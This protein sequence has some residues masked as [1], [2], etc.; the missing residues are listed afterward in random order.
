MKRSIGAIVA[1]LALCL[2]AVSVANAA[3]L[4]LT[5][6]SVS[7]ITAAD[8]CTAAADVAPGPITGGVTQSVVLSGL[9]PACANKTASIT[10][11][12]AQGSAL[13]TVTEQNIG[14]ITAGKATVTVPPATAW[15][16]DGA[17]L[18]LGTW[19]IST[20]F[21][22][23]PLP[24]LSCTIEGR[25][26]VVCSVS[27]SK[28]KLNTTNFE[29]TDVKISTLPKV[30]GAKYQVAVN[31]ADPWFASSPYPLSTIRGL[32]APGTL[33]LGPGMTCASRPN[34][35]LVGKRAD[36]N[37][38]GADGTAGP[39]YISGSSKKPAPSSESLLSCP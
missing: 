28:T 18:T 8:R 20:T 32:A 15:S 10:L 33:I 35:V 3:T 14:A 36:N 16:L 22:K 9:D 24:L 21:T 1:V 19:G 26:D 12:D 31:L 5:S 17:A 6:L 11:Y 30:K 34:I 38:T 37:K 27:Y 7:T 23:P 39:F 25:P 2:A 29:L 13:S 4:N